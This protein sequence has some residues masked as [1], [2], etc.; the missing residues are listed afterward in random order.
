MASPVQAI[1]AISHGGST[2]LSGLAAA[3]ILYNVRRRPP[4]LPCL[5]FSVCSPVAPPFPTSQVV[6]SAVT[7][8]PVTRVDAAL[9]SHAPHSPGYAKWSA[10]KGFPTTSTMLS[11]ETYKLFDAKKWAGLPV[12][13]QV[14]TPRGQ[15]EL[16]IGM[17]RLLDDTLGERGFGQGA[18]KP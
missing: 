3:T 18:H 10:T 4:S 14:I 1:P 8:L 13:V 2:K 11:A 5:P 7:V 15:E 16:S 6:D 9:D 17:M 12:G